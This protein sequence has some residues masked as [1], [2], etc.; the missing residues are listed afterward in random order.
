MITLLKKHHKNSGSK[1]IETTLNDDFDL[2]TADTANDFDNIS[3]INDINDISDISDISD[4]PEISADNVNINIQTVDIINDIPEIPDE[5][6]LFFDMDGVLMLYDENFYKPVDKNNR[7]TIYAPINK[8]GAH[9][10][11]NTE[12]CMTMIEAVRTLHELSNDTKI[13]VHILSGV[14]PTIVM[15]EHVLD[16]FVAINDI[17]PELNRDNIHIAPSGLKVDYIEKFLNR[18]INAKDILIDDYPKNLRQWQKHGGTAIKA[19]NDFNT[20]HNDFNYIDT[21]DESTI[22]INKI[23][24]IM[25]N[26]HTK[27]VNNL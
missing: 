11:L 3:D 7:P 1:I 20:N 24:E 22:I 10:F 21:R 14:N 2:Q 4:I 25:A 12:P 18:P 27:G 26:I 23:F 8:F 17:L 16:K 13:N 15:T 6:N 19:L 5:Y 9:I